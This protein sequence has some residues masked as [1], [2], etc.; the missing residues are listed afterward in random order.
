MFSELRPQTL[1]HRFQLFSRAARAPS[2]DPTIKNAPASPAEALRYPHGES[3]PG[4]R[5]ENPTPTLSI[6]EGNR[7]FQERGSKIGSSENPSVRKTTGGDAAAGEHL[8]AELEAVISAWPMLPD[9]VRRGIMAMV[10]AS[11][12]GD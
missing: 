4:F 5:T 6:A 7:D 12:A 1:F 9:A 2:H 3:N 10:E 8:D 11:T